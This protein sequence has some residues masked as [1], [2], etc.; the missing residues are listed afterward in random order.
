M[1]R[2]F[3]PEAI[4]ISAAQAADDVVIEVLVRGE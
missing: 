3:G 1:R 2:A 4:V